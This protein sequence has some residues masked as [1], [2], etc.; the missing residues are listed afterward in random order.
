[1]RQRLAAS[2]LFALLAT[3]AFTGVAGATKGPDAADVAI[4]T[5]VVV[6]VAMALLALIFGVK[7]A[8]GLEA[9][10]PPEE[11]AAHGADHH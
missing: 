11:P 8:L 2:L 3:F 1:M 6:V 5:A 10:L 7:T 4:G 9:P